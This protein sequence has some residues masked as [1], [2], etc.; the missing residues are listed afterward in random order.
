M[1]IKL[2]GVM[3]TLLIP[4]AARTQETRSDNPRI[5][6]IKAVEISNKIDYDFSKYNKA[7]SQQG[8]IARTMILDRETQKFIDKY[9][10]GICI[11]IGCG[12]DTRYHRVKHGKIRWYNLD[13]PEVI[14][15]RKKVL[16]EG[17]NVKY[18]SKSALDISWVDDVE[19]NEHVLIILEGILMYFTQEEVIQLFCM[20][21][22]NFTNCEIL[23]E[24]MNPIV[25]KNTKYHDTV[26]NT[27]AIF[28]WGIESGKAMERICD[29][30]CFEQEW[31]LFDELKEQG[32]M[33]KI[34]AAVPFIRNINNKIVK[35]QMK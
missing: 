31:N 6:D 17:K 14:Q 33:F 9:P 7:M 4:L 1:Q 3:E 27:S 20:L 26:K 10:D 15:I 11:S 12:L 13:F 25:A 18:I 24:I 34:A 21:K 22:N 35:L 29:N 32:I 23:A 8:V 5:R 30:M 28:K 16:F 19:K 2:E